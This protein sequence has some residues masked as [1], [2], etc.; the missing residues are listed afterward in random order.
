MNYIQF[1][2]LDRVTITES[3]K[4]LTA[5]EFCMEEDEYQ[6]MIDHIGEPAFITCSNDECFNYV[7][8]EFEDGFSLDSIS[9]EGFYS[10]NQVVKIQK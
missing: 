10:G 7:S 1:N 4:D 2:N 5:S 6:Q 8:L 3:V 9:V